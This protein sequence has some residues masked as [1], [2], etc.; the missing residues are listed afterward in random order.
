MYWRCRLQKCKICVILLQKAL[1][2]SYA[3]LE[4]VSWQRNS[5]SLEGL[6]SKLCVYN[7]QVRHFRCVEYKLKYN[8]KKIYNTVILNFVFY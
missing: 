6:P 1:W 4:I 5:F 3:T 8:I 7:F 2:Q